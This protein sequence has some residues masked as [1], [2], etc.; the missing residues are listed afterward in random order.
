MSRG[1]RLRATV[2]SLATLGTGLALAS[3]AVAATAAPSTPID[4]FNGYRYCSTDVNS[5]TYLSNRGG[6]IIEG[7]TPETDPYTGLLTLQF[8]VWPAD[9]STQTTTLSNQYVSSGYEGSVEVP[10]A[11]LSDGRTYAWRAQAVG[12][13][14]ASEWSAPCFFR[15]DATRPST[16]PTITSSNYPEGEATQGGAPVQITLGANGASDVEG[17]VFSWTG[18][19]SFPVIGADIGAYG[20]PKPEDPYAYPQ[21]FARAS[22]LGGSASVNLIPPFGSGSMTL[23]VASLDRARNRSAPA[24]Y[25]IYVNSTEPTIEQ[26]T[27]DPEFDGW[28]KFLLHPAPG[29][30]AASPVVEYNV[31]FSGQTDQTINV[32]AAADG[33]ARVRVKLDGTLGNT[34][35][36]TSKSADGWVSDGAF[37][38]HTFDTTPTV[39]S[40]VY[41]ENQSGGGVGVPG[42]FTFTPK[43]EHVVSYTYSFNYGTPVTVKA[44]LGHA[45]TISWTPGQSGFT[46]LQ[47]YATTSDGI[48]LEPYYYSFTVS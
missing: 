8:Q 46:N 26:L 3:P 23:T 12:T 47:V 43:V 40:D 33:T 30:Q 18:E 1:G 4:L 19:G 39:G 9:D 20:V 16:A 5:P 29:L 10:E 27:R 41:P 45:A 25:T 11:N 2:V 42:T 15:V 17:Y 14:G 7:R 34:M 32:E 24:T 44:G 35:W 6:V 48:Q 38:N 22:A 13:G 37:W 31:K 21:S 36:V 28:A